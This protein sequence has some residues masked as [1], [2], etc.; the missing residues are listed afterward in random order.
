MRKINQH[1]INNFLNELNK[2]NVETRSIVV[3]QDN[4]VLFK[5]AYKPFDINELHPLYSC[6]KTFTCMAIG[7]L[8]DEGKLALDDVWQDY[9][10]EYQ[11]IADPAFKQITIKHILTMSIGQDGDPIC[12]NDDDWFENTLRKKVIYKPGSEFFYNTFATCLL[13]PLVKRI[14]GKTLAKYVQDNIFKPLGI[15]E[16]NWEQDKHTNSIGGFGLH[17][18]IMDLAKFGNCLCN[19]GKYKNKQILPEWFVKEATSKQIDNAKYYPEFKTESRSGYGYQIWMNTHNSYRI[20][21]MHAQ[22]C[23]IFPQD[24]LVIAMNNAA[25][26]SQNVLNPLWVVLDENLNSQSSKVDF[27]VKLLKGKSLAKSNI[28]EKVF[29]KHKAA[30]NIDEVSDIKLNRIGNDLELIINRHHKKYKLL[31]G[32]NKWQM[33]EADFKDFSEFFWQSS[34]KP[35]KTTKNRRRVF[36]NY[37]VISDTMFKIQLRQIDSTFCHYFI[38]QV[39]GKYLTMMYNVEYCYT[40]K[41]SFVTSFYM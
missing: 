10:P 21:G 30:N 24:K 31:A 14:S 13:S 27:T 12:L 4:K 25:M 37:A 2:N 41:P 39:D 28:D 15:K 9:F 35:Q 7:L 23:F 19:L 26:S 29:R 40:S 33:C 6:T 1:I 11:K 32:Y 17:L 18:K 20:S 16:Y 3:I 34:C 8:I 5:H 36:A 38:F 22:N